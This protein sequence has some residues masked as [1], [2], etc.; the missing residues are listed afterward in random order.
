MR[1][2]LVLVALMA[3]LTS[4]GLA[5]PVSQ[6]P[7]MNLMLSQ[8]KIEI[9][10][11]VVA[12]ATF[13]PPV[14]KPGQDA[15]YRVSLNAL[16]ESIEWPARIP[17][18][19]GLELRPG[20][21][22]E[23]LQMTMPTL[24]PRSSFNYMARPEAVGRF[25]APSFSIRVYNQTVTVPATTLEVVASPP[26]GIPPAPRLALELGQSNLFAGQP[27]RARV[28]MSSPANGALQTLDQVQLTGQ[29]FIVDK[30]MVRQRIETMVRDG[31]ARPT[32]V[33]ET[34][35]TPLTAG[36]V[37]LFAQGFTTGNRFSGT[38]VITGPAT[39]AGNQISGGGG[40]PPYSLLDSEPVELQVRPL[41]RRGELPGFTGAIGVLE[42]APPLLSSNVLM[43]GEPAKMVVVV[44][45]DNPL[46]RLIAPMPPKLPDWQVLLSSTEGASAQVKPAARASRLPVL[47]VFTYTLLPMSGDVKGTP[48]LP[49]SFF[50]PNRECYVD[51]SVPSVPVTVRTGLEAADTEAMA[52]ADKIE[53]EAEKE[54]TLS[55]L[56]R[57][58]GLTT[59]RLMPVQ[60]EAWF[61]LVQMA[62]ALAFL[63]LWAWDR[64][65][66]FLEQHPEIVLR[67]RA[68]R[69]LRRER[70]ALRRAA[71]TGDASGY[72]LRA[73]NAMRHGCAP[74]YPAEPG[75][76][77]G[78]D[79]LALFPR[80]DRLGK[81]GE[82][83]KRFFAV[84]D[85]AQFA[86]APTGAADL[87]SLQPEMENV[88]S[89]LE[90]RLET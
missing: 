59:G 5:Q 35:L 27:V 16:S 86:G 83:V 19:P 52:Q 90:R 77:V 42:M 68:L 8:P 45:G 54:T 61:P 73:V 71:Q 20:A 4:N 60:E 53:P 63:C 7:L 46:I 3:F 64:R 21:R 70:Q 36:S 51:L 13:D 87:L 23:I 84:A 39:L 9:A 85:A 50:D 30:G 24:Q 34:S 55:E 40:V 15:I 75:A 2:G 37:S 82:V 33:Y 14:V 56:A 81:M 65:R 67:R 74:H 11:Q 38:I 1:A 18:P 57:S 66:R 80:A 44:H 31:V 78:A 49:F 10:T 28:L 79:V 22:G 58:P 88:L 12:V 47:A 62:P 6:D 76:L 32:F 48:V 29:G 25:T 41:P 69:A 26:A 17:N 72:A 43:L 89:E